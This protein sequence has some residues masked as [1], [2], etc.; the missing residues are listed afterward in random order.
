[1]ARKTKTVNIDRAKLAAWLTRRKIS[2]AEMSSR[3]GA[4]YSYISGVLCGQFEISV[5]Y[6]K[7][8]CAELEVPE[9]TFMIPEQ[10]EQPV[11]F[12]AELLEAAPPEQ[13]DEICKH[14]SEISAKLDKIID[15]W[16]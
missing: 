6:Y 1:M 16:R 11:Q 12:Q 10:T 14:L 4:G 15:S 7:A 13:L 9:D 3:I 5:P 2:H 8:L